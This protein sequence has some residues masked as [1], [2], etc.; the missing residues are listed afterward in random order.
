MTAIKMLKS[1]VCA[2]YK[3]QHTSVQSINVG[4]S[5]KLIVRCRRNGVRLMQLCPR[6]AIMFA[7]ERVGENVCVLGKAEIPQY[8]KEA[9]ACQ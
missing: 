4:K 3:R 5:S 1:I 2:P 9:A 6:V 8:Q 7:R